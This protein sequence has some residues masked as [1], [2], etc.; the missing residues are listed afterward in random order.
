[1]KSFYGKY[2]VLVVDAPTWCGVYVNPVLG[3]EEPSK[4]RS[5]FGWV[6]KRDGD[7]VTKTR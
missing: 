3:R 2:L 4:L 7:E 6:T 1:V 5:G